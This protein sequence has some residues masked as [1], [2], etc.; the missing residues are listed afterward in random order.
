MIAFGSPHRIRDIAFAGLMLLVTS[1]TARAEYLVAPG[2]TIEVRVAGASELSQ[3][4]QVQQDGTVSLPGVG[5]IRVA[6]LGL[7]DMRA[8]IGAMLASKVLR[9][10]TPDGQQHIV[11]IQPGDVTVGM[12][13]YAPI[14]VSGDVFNPGQHPYRPARTVRQVI[15]LAGGYSVVHG[16]PTESADPIEVQSEYAAIGAKFVQELVHAARLQAELDGKKDLAPVALGDIPV[17]KSAIAELVRG[18]REALRISAA[19]YELQQTFL[20]N[21]I[22][23]ATDQLGKQNAELAEEEKGLQADEQDLAKAQRAYGNGNLPSPR[24][25]ESRHSLMATS[26]KILDINSIINQ[27]RQQ[28]EDFTLKLSHLK[29]DRQMQLLGGLGDSRVRLVEFRTK[30]KTLR[31]RIDLLENSRDQGRF[32]QT[33]GADYSIVRKLGNAWTTIP[34]SIDTELQP[35]DVITVHIKSLPELGADDSDVGY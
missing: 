9:Q 18:E 28:L 35:G 21:G 3:R 1:Y 11:A 7:A 19:D 32:E 4:A 27:T 34:A 33:R 31:R 10:R 25:L 22:R 12:A 13:E 29:S 26:S 23:R 30:L 24:I 6:G 2:D 5:D 14:Y 15:A 20:L 8:K 17:P 16:R